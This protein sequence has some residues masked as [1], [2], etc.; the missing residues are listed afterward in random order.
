MTHIL[1]AKEVQKRK[2]HHLIPPCRDLEPDPPPPPEI[3]RNWS[4]ASSRFLIGF[5]TFQKSCLYVH[6]ISSFQKLT[7]TPANIRAVK[8]VGCRYYSDS[9]NE[10]SQNSGKLIP[11]VVTS[12]RVDRVAAS[13]LGIA[14]R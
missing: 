9:G 4:M 10:N 8:V 6:C 1:E 7:I 12:L 13:G 5:C 2:I 14:R 11:L 3:K